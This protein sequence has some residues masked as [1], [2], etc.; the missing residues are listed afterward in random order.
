A[1]ILFFIQPQSV[2]DEMMV[3]QTDLVRLRLVRMSNVPDTLYMVNNAVPQCCHMI[4]H[5]QMVGSSSTAPSDMIRRLHELRHTEQVQRAYALNCGE[6]ATVSYELQL[7][8]LREFGLADGATELLQNP[9]KFFPDERFGDESPILALRQVGRCRVNS[10]PAMDSMITELEGMGVEPMMREFMP[11]IALGVSVMSLREQHMADMD[12]EGPHSPMGP[13][14]HHVPHGPCASARL[15]HGYGPGHGHSCK[16]HA[17]EPKLEAQAEFPDL[18]DFSCRPAT[19]TSSHPL[20]TFAGPDLYSH[21]CTQSGSYPP[22]Y[23]SDCQP[24]IHLQGRTAPDP[25]RLDVLGKKSQR[26][27]LVLSS[28]SGAQPRTGQF[29]KGRP[30]ET[31]LTHGL[32]HLRSPSGNMDS[33]EERHMGPRD[34][35]EEMVLGG[36]SSGP[37][38]LQQSH[39]NSVGEELLRDRR[40]PS[41]P[42]YPYKKSAL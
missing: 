4:S 28:P 26:H 40:S 6:G 11:D 33:Y 23:V 20:P 41:K 39:R 32:G 9:S 17:P 27:D 8:V 16:R 18:Y 1:I 5:Q 29:P 34:A 15:S 14:G 31:D 24:H 22:P 38:P 35:P 13:S 2:L 19:P 42:D 36:D 7:R 21:S 30:N 12:R 25:L 37:G 3:E 10:S